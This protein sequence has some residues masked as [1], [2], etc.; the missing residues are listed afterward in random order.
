MLEPKIKNGVIIVVT[1]VWSTNFV[2][3]L[4]LKGYEPD[5]TIN[6]IFMAIVGGLFALGGKGNNGGSSG[7]GGSHKGE[8]PVE[9][10][11]KEAR[12]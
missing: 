8:P 7:E 11:P 5:Q 3:G 1:L 4:F 12:S 9:E 2:S 6:A 10:K